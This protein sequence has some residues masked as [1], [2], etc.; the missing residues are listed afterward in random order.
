MIEATIYM[1][2]IISVVYY[3]VLSVKNL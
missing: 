1:T 2:S 3:I